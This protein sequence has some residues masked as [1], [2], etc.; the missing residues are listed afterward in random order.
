VRAAAGAAAAERESD[1]RAFRRRG[2]E[3]ERGQRGR[4]ERGKRPQTFR[5]KGVNRVSRS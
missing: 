5:E 1:A 3:G 2:R 4:E